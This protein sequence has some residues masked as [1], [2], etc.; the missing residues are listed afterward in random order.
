[1]F[2]QDMNDDQSFSYQDPDQ[3]L[4]YQSNDQSLAYQNTQQTHQ[5][6]GTTDMRGQPPSSPRPTGSAPSGP[7]TGAIIALTVAILLVFSVGLFAGWQFHSSSSP[8]S[9]VDGTGTGLQPGNP[10]SQVQIPKLSG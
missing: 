7:R 9:F 1:M 5:T 6:L 10:V 8:V 2:H 4:P 3:S